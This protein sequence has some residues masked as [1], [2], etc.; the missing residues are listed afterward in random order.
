M[1]RY[2]AK[3]TNIF[4]HEFTVETAD[5]KTG[6]GFR[7]TWRNNMSEASCILH[8]Q[9]TVNCNVARFAVAGRV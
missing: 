8:F 3:L 9:L 1:T 5:T 4:S 6:L 7:Q 2:G